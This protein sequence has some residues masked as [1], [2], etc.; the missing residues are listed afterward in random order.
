MFFHHLLFRETHFQHLRRHSA[1]DAT[2]WNIFCNN[3][4]G[5]DNRTTPNRHAADDNRPISNP[6]II[7]DDSSATVPT[8]RIP[9]RNP[10]QIGGMIVFP[11]QSHPFGHQD[12]VA[13]FTVSVYHT[14]GPKLNAIAQRNVVVGRKDICSPRNSHPASPLD[15][16]RLQQEKE[17]RS[18]E[19]C[20]TSN[21]QH[22]P[23]TTRT[24]VGIRYRFHC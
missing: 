23:G 18:N 22:Q 13:D 2:G 19:I 14:P 3:S 10:G 9:D 1:G 24:N 16:T 5:G 12:T 21:L 17:F 6:D 15:I 4:P 11:N 8:R 7:P 20:K